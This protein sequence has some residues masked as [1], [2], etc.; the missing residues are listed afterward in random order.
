MQYNKALDYTVLALDSL[1]QGKP[2]LA[3]RLLAKAGEQ[4]DLTA[5]IQILEHSNKAAH[6]AELKAK[7][8]AKT[9][10]P[11]TRLKAS[12]EVVE[13]APA[14]EMEVEEAPAVEV[15]VEEVAAVEEDEFAGD[16]LDEVDP[17]EEEPA[18]APAVAMA[19]ALKKLVRKTK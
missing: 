12:E 1:R 7:L 8:E 18:P 19:A 4:T 5:A 13:E 2:V 16:P 10:S 11:A 14:P 9:T 6:A 17:V 15:E 3:A